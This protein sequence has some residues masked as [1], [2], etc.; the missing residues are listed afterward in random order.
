[1]A[2]NPYLTATDEP[3]EV[4]PLFGQD[5]ETL[6]I[7]FENIFLSLR[8]RCVYVPTLVTQAGFLATL[9]TKALTVYAAEESPTTVQQTNCQEIL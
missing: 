8:E 7:F 9:W 6:K 1:M 3:P 5:Q 4:N 2:K